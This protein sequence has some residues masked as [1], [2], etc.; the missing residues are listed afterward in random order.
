MKRPVLI[1]LSLLLTLGTASAQVRISGFRPCPQDS[2]PGEGGFPD[3]P[4]GMACAALLL[5]TPVSGWTFDAGLT[6]IVETRYEDGSVWIYVPAS[7]RK[8]TVAH[9]S[10]GVLRDWPFPVTLEP[11]RTYTMTL[12]A[13][14]PRQAPPTRSVPTS[15]VKPS[16]PRHTAVPAR[17]PFPKE[18][19]Q[20]EFS[21][22]F[23]DLYVGFGCS[24]SEGGAFAGSGDTW[25]GFSYTWIGG[26]IGPYLSLGTDFGERH[27]LSAGIAYRLTSPRTASLDWQL[28]GGVGMVAG[29]LGGEVGTRLGWRSAS[30]LSRWD[31]GAGCQFTAGA[32]IP[33]VS[34]GL[35]IWGIPA[36]VGVGLVVC[37]HR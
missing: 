2:R 35:Y 32:I 14:Q 7:A 3:D 13:E 34:V 30:R 28:Y 20:K 9:R 15:P 4:D 36:L 12:C 17:D 18:E 19:V 23:A 26:R 1:A 27:T 8:L 6:G 29:A 31:I 10:Y 22:H 16:P 5:S 24:R 37:A 21:Q 25:L 11:G 33:T